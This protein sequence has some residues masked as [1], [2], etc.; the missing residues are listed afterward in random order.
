MNRGILAHIES[1]VGGDHVS[2]NI[3]E[4]IKNA[5]GTFPYGP[6]RKAPPYCVV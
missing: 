3:F 5:L 2:E 1:I 6:D 4:K